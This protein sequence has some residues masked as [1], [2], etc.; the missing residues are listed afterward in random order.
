M[1]NNH[2]VVCVGAVSHGE[3]IIARINEEAE[4]SCAKLLEEARQTSSGL[5]A[6][7]RAKAKASS[8]TIDQDSDTLVG[9]LKERIFSA[10]NLEKRKISLA[11]KDDFARLVLG[12]LDSLAADLRKD[13]NAYRQFLIETIARGA[14]ILEA[15]SIIAMYSFLDETVLKD[16]GFST[17]LS[18]RAPGCRLELKKADFTDIGLLLSTS[19]GLTIYDNR[20]QARLK[21]VLPE[22]YQGIIDK[23]V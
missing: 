5:I 22:V 4:H 10:L 11:A 6:G 23:F 20:F 14:R 9:A 2:A 19:D 12:R 13:R 3:T 21:R 18:A 1:K 16:E 8:E 7:A 15:P 17:E